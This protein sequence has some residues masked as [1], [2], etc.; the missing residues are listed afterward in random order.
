MDGYVD[1]WIDKKNLQ[2]ICPA[3]FYLY[4][5]VQNC[6]TCHPEM[7]GSWEYRIVVLAI[8]NGASVILQE[9]MAPLARRKG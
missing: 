3:N 9:M 6:A 2:K 5:F 8:L 4:L 1:G 7:Q